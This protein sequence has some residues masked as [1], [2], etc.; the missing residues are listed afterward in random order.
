MQVIGVVPKSCDG[1]TFGGLLRN[2]IVRSA[3]GWSDFRWSGSGEYVR[4]ENVD[5]DGVELVLASFIYAGRA[6]VEAACR[7]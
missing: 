6:A 4:A 5:S 2:W 3:L 1:G 7:R